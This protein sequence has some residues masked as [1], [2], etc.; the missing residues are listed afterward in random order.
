MFRWL[1]GGWTPD[2]N[3]EQQKEY[4]RAR[5]KE[6]ADLNR[7]QGREQR[8]D[9]QERDCNNDATNFGSSGIFGWCTSH[10]PEDKDN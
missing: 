8:S 7:V 1:G 2:R 10:D 3:E 9:C 6:K 4:D 5:G